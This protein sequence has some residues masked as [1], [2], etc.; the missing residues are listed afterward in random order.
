M[1]DATSSTPSTAAN[2]SGAQFAPFREIS[3][4]LRWAHS[5]WAPL[6]FVGLSIATI[7]W[8]DF[9]KFYA[10][11]VS[12]FSSGLLAAL[13]AL[14]ATVTFVVMLLSTNA[15]MPAF[16][17]WIDVHK[18][19]T[20]LAA[21]YRQHIADAAIRRAELEE[22]KRSAASKPSDVVAGRAAT[23]PL[24]RNYPDL[25]LRWLWL[26]VFVGLLWAGWLVVI[27]YNP[28]LSPNWVLPIIFV[29]SLVIAVTIFWRPVA[30]MNRGRP[31]WSFVFQFAC[32]IASQ[33]I[34]T[35]SV[36][37]IILATT[38]DM[39]W[40]TLAAKGIVF[41]SALIAIAATQLVTASRVIQGPYKNMLKHACVG[42]IGVMAAIAT[43]QPVG[44][45]LATYPLRVSGPDGRACMI[46]HLTSEDTKASNVA[47]SVRDNKHSGYT[48][49]LK[50]VTHF[51]DT[52]YVKM[53]PIN[54]AVY[55]IPA[56]LIN[57]FDSCPSAKAPP[58][59]TQTT[60]HANMPSGT[61]QAASSAT[62][63]A[64]HSASTIP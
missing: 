2:T 14:F 46:L 3:E 33:N 35:F 21:A 61:V 20:S 59:D 29:L 8:I 15:V 10:I 5:R 31:S 57:E 28:D 43:V 18:D 39:Q 49:P 54:G 13:P 37:Y 4:V 16:L 36:L 27:C 48:V 30:A 45:L 62:T 23:T 42:V 7:L 11:P 51:D 52:Y 26:S 32:G 56:A 22:R 58:A 44:A 19:G 1:S 24:S 47:L 50:F 60:S 63:T 64:P 55:P 17:L 41:L 40:Q 25:V 6:A 38:T 53:Q 34:V 9:L 12:F